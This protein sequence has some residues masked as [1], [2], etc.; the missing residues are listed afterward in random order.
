[1]SIDLALLHPVIRQMA[2]SVLFYCESSGLD[3]YIPSTGGVRNEKDQIAIYGKER[4]TVHY[5]GLAVDFQPRIKCKPEEWSARFNAWP[6]WNTLQ[7]EICVKCGFDKPQQWQIDRDRPHVQ[8]LFGVPELTLKK[9]WY[10]RKWTKDDVW[11][12]I[13]KPI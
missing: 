13:K 10:D 9:L 7:C 12:Y 2:E 4:W 8:K 5:T 1:M 11:E 3:V 6:H